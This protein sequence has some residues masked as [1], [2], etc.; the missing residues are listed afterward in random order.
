MAAQDKRTGELYE[1]ALRVFGKYGYKKATVE[2]IA[3]ELG[4][5]KGALYQYT[6]NKRTL[7]E[8]SVEYGMYKWQEKTLDTVKDIGD[9]VL[10]L[11]ILCRNALGYLSKDINLRT[12]IM[13]DPDVFPISFKMDP[14]KDLNDSSM[15]Y[16]KSVLD[17]GVKSKKFRDIDT[18]I[19]TK[20]LF[21]IYKMLILETYVLEEQD[22]DR[23]YDSAIDLI[24]R[25]FVI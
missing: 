4:L 14:Y 17:E 9:V 18:D 1:A 10:K 19:M 5:T 23:V 6:K 11:K 3:Q 21:S 20:L 25:G 7:Y 8:K 12:I 22:L 24:L 16:L 2:D 15:K 13:H